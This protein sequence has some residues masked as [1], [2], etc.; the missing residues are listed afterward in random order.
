MH[1]YE[2]FFNPTKN[3]LREGWRVHEDGMLEQS[4]Y[5]KT[6]KPIRG[7]KQMKK[8]LRRTFAP[9]GE[10]SVN[11]VNCLTSDTVD[12]LA[13]IYEVDAAELKR[14]AASRHR[15]KPMITFNDIL[16]SGT[17][18]QGPLC[19]IAI[20]FDGEC[21]VAYDGDGEDVPHDADWGEGYVSH[22]YY[23]AVNECMTVDIE[24]EE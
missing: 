4:F 16:E 10:Y 2:L 20:S 14:D 18:F 8:H 22:V 23:D 12:A 13:S 9:T 17:M 24:E 21:A 1:Y 15:R 6:E 7:K 5:V 19:V 11:L 3:L